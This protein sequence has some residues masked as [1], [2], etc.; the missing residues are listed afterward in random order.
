MYANH[1]GQGLLNLQNELEKAE[2]ILNSFLACG[3]ECRLLIPFANSF[4][5]RSGPTEQRS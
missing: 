2:N 1:A 5:P 4:E 3:D